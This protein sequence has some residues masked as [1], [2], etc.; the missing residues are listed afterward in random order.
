VGD[1]GKRHCIF[2]GN[3]AD[4]REH[5]L[6]EWVRKILPSDQPV[7]HYRK[8]GG[9]ETPPWRKKP[10]R[11]KAKFVCGSCNH[12]WMSDLEKETKPLLAPAITHERSCDFDLVGQWVLARWA[13]KTC[14][15]MQMQAPEPLAPQMHPVLLNLNFIPPPHVTVWIGSHARAI[16]DPINS[17]Y[18]QQPL[19]LAQDGEHPREQVEFGYMSFLAVGG[20]SFLLVEHRFNSYVECVLGEQHPASNMFTKIWPR[21]R[22][23]VP[24][25]P[26]TMADQELLDLIFDAETL[27]L[28]FDPRFFPGKLHEAPFREAA[29]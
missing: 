14:Y 23:V 7:T 11:E 1:Q 25:P 26:T 24:W 12:G 21:T 17:A 8:V 18:V 22:R 10:F 13:A 2:C 20:V 3:A 16:Q 28:G 9:V 27:P 15:V 5:L 6:P 29:Y 4:D 19:W